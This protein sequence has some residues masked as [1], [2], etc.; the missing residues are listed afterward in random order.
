M[1]KAWVASIVS[2][3]YQEDWLH[4]CQIKL[5][6]WSLFLVFDCSRDLLFKRSTQ[7]VLL[8]YFIAVNV[9]GNPSLQW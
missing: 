7:T 5:L 1:A 4:L 9:H 3:G 8:G 2:P 6:G